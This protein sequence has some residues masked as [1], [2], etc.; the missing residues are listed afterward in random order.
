MGRSGRMRVGR[1]GN[2]KALGGG[3]ARKSQGDE[4]YN[5]YSTQS[6]P[7]VN[8][9]SMVVVY[10]KMKVTCVRNCQSAPRSGRM[11]L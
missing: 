11:T 7:R 10:Q 6:L 3:A 5:T 8:L 1:D 2:E 9:I 4:K